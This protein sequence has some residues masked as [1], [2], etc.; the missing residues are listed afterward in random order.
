MRYPSLQDR[1]DDQD[2]LL[3]VPR[4]QKPL[5]V[6]ESSARSDRHSL[7]PMF[8]RLSGCISVVLLDQIAEWL[9]DVNVRAAIV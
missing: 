2:I 6:D 9:D 1:V 3:R 8:P 4:R 7:S 5:H